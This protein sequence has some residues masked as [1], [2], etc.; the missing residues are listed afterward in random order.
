MVKLHKPRPA[1]IQ[2]AGRVHQP[3]QGS[4][5]QIHLLMNR[6]ARVLKTIFHQYVIHL[7][8]ILVASLTLMTLF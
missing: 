2:L 6:L 1:F 3:G 4:N 5:K 8:H 7:Y